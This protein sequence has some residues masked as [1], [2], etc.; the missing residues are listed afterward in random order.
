MGGGSSKFG[1]S[2]KVGPLKAVTMKPENPADMT[3][4]I[5]HLVGAC[6]ALAE[7]AGTVIRGV[8]SQGVTGM[9]K[10]NSG[11]SRVRRRASIDKMLPADALTI[12]DGRAQDLIISSLRERWPRLNLIGEED[13][14]VQAGGAAHGDDHNVEGTSIDFSVPAELQGLSWDEVCVWVDPVDGTK[15][16]IMGDAQNGRLLAVTTL[17]GISLRGRPIAGII[18]EPFRPTGAEGTERLGHTTWGVVGVGNFGVVRES[19]GPLPPVLTAY[20]GKMIVIASPNKSNVMNGCIDDLKGK[21]SAGIVHLNAC[22]NKELRLLEQKGNVMLQGPSCGRWDICAAEALL[23]AA[24]GIVTDLD[25]KLIVYDHKA[26]SHKCTKGAL[27][28]LSPAM[29][30]KAL[31][32]THGKMALL[33]PDAPSGMLRRRLSLLI[34]GSMVFKSFRKQPSSAQLKLGVTEHS[35]EKVLGTN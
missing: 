8:H 19:E 5:Q 25:G 7:R 27:A 28:S 6:I 29:H 23:L 15:E 13:D 34:S 30:A 9:S 12:A 4:D 11:G 20:N 24:G 21:C 26:Y 3:V 33:C 1:N 18:H 16:F 31:A 32:A 2:S 22:G 14:E 35:P 17:I 10:D